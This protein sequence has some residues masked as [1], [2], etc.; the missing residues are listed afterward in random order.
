MRYT[1][2]FVVCDFFLILAFEL[3]GLLA[4]YWPT[5]SEWVWAGEVSLRDVGHPLLIP[6]IFGILFGALL[7]HFVNGGA[8]SLKFYDIRTA[9]VFIALLA[10]FVGWH[11]VA[12][13]GNG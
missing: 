8:A 5:I 10:G 3:L 12:P 13:A 2:L 1:T 7:C 6:T 11:L 9:V 4:S